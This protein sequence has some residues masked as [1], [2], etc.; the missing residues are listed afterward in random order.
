VANNF[1]KGRLAFHCDNYPEDNPY[2][3][4]T[5]EAQEWDDGWLDA[6]DDYSEARAMQH[7]TFGQSAAITIFGVL[8]V[9]AIGAIYVSLKG[10]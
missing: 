2:V 9:L 8:A 6:Y 10:A 4:G 3:A 1:R 7:D 5:P